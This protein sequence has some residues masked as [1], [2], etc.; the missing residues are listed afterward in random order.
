MTRI[1]PVLIL[2]V[3]VPGCGDRSATPPPA[4]AFQVSWEV[5]HPNGGYTK[6]GGESGTARLGDTALAAK[7]RRVF[8]NRKDGGPLG[9]GDAVVVDK[10]G[11]LFVNGQERAT[12]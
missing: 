8:L 4:P 11:R 7:D 12:R 10:D 1:A 3:V 5:R 6:G 9:N 2:A